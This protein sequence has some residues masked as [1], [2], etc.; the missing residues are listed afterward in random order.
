MCVCLCL[1]VC[2]CLCVCARS[3]VTCVCMCVCMCHL[4]VTP[5]CVCMCVRACAF[6]CHLCM[7]VCRLCVTLVCVCV[8][9]C[10]CVRSRVDVCRCLLKDERH[11]SSAHELLEHNFIKTPLG[12]V[13]SPSRGAELKQPPKPGMHPPSARPNEAR[14]LRHTC[15]GENKFSSAD[16]RF[17]TE[18]RLQSP[19]T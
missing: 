19:S 10:V 2:V 9:V 8:C 13:P 7:C 11:R 16:L 18:G 6:V 14:C 15:P 17:H 3:C 4:C 12:G 5:V 1:C